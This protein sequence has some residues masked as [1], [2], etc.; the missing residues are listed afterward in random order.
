[1]SH[2]D[3][4][5][6]PATPTEQGPPYAGPPP[7]AAP[8]YGYYGVPAPYGP[9][10]YGH[11]PGPYGY[12]YGYPPYGYWPTPPPRP[13]KPG[14]V[15]TAAVLALVQAGLVLLASGYVF[16]L[17]AAA[18]LA[19]TTGAAVAGDL[20]AEGRVVATVQL[21]SVVLLVVAGVQLLGRRSRRVWILGLAA[22]A[23]QV[24][25]SLYWMVR[26]AALLDD[27]PGP[28]PAAP[29]VSF[30]LFF[31]VAPLVGL[32]MLLFGPGRRWFAAPDAG[33][34]SSA[35]PQSPAR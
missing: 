17:A 21:L 35:G 1:M 8:P 13:R 22:L 19:G 6:D 20:A 3:P 4:W 5:A 2:P 14:Q 12:P 30:A 25:L 9:P 10:A 29:F 15:I 33:G 31:A 26:I 24:V 23:V 18:D 7:T 32:G 28:D 34:G 16:L 11:P 27:V